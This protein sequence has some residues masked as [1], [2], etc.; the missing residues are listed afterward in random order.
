MNGHRLDDPNFYELK[1][2]D[3]K[4]ISLLW[5]IAME[6]LGLFISKSSTLSNP[7]WKTAKFIQSV[8][9]YTYIVWKIGK[10]CWNA[11]TTDR[12]ERI[13]LRMTY[14][15][16]APIWIIRAK[17]RLIGCW[18]WFIRYDFPSLT[19]LSIGARAQLQRWA[20]PPWP[21][22]CSMWNEG[23]MC[24]TDVECFGNDTKANVLRW[25]V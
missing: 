16:T 15:K 11:A 21:A 6:T 13:D 7:Y 24:F 4:A 18:E 2:R 19:K 17:N 14:T 25:A 3:R 12:I 8:K 23:R 20:E 22:H 5:S 10:V 1:N 9:V